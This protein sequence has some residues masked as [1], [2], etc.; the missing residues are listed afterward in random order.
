MSNPNPSPKTRF[1]EGNPGRP[2]GI[3]NIKTRIINQLLQKT[4][5][6]DLANPGVVVGTGKNARKE[7]KKLKGS[8]ADKVIASLIH[9]A[10]NGNINAAKILFEWGE[11]IPFKG[12]P[13]GDDEPVRV[14]KVEIKVIDPN[15]HMKKE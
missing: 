11:G 5:Y 14:T 3:L 1:K 4:L 10:V 6:P 7:L 8:M 12:E 9:E 13:E 15:G 2:K